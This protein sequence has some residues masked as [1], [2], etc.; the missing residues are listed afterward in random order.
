MQRRGGGREGERV[1]LGRDGHGRRC[2]E[3]HLAPSQGRGGLYTTP[4]TE[5]A[6][7]P[8]LSPAAGGR[9]SVPP[10]PNP[11]GDLSTRGPRRARSAAA[12][13][14]RLMHTAL[15][16]DTAIERARRRPAAARRRRPRGAR[17]SRTS[18]PAA[19]A[20]PGRRSHP[21]DM[22]GPMRAALGVAL[23]IEGV[24]AD[25]GRRARAGRRGRGAAAA[26]P[27]RRRRR[28][29]ERDRHGRRC[30]CSSRA[31]RRPARE[32]WCP[33]NEGSGKVLR[34]GADDAEVVERLRWMRDVL[35]P[36]LA[37]GARAHRAARPD[38]AAAA[39][40]PRAATS[41]TTAP[42]RARGCS[43]DA[44]AERAARRRAR[45]HPRQPPVLPQRRDGRG[46]GRHRG[47]G[48]R[49]GLAARDRGR[50]QRRRGRRA[51]L[52][53]GRRVVHRPG[54]RARPGA[55]GARLRRRRTC[56]A[57]SAT[58]RSSRST[59]SAR[60]RWR[61]RRCRRRPSASTPPTRPR[62]RRACAGSPRPSIPSSGLGR[63]RRRSSASTRAPSCASG[64]VPPIHT[65]IAHREPGV[66]Q[67]GGGVTLPPLEAFD[68]GRGARSTAAPRRVTS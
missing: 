1:R 50:A 60:W 62:S 58:R 49:A 6:G 41:A 18:P 22:C 65:G 57:T 53:H 35:G 39:R 4:S 16:A 37:R 5:V 21:P 15:Y 56:S 26:Q 43:H 51:A 13:G 14:C 44:L 20:T 61:R 27:R 48:G 66:G 46:E 28:A 47:R 54:R 3:V 31:T 23:A 9:H 30:R 12:V 64:I 11:R 7:G 52:G 2:I 40:A 29:D 25:A 24:A 63:R 55:P 33:L 59:G 45:V 36:A 67:I 68:A 38:R 19:R 10:V 17:S 8:T 32:A 42:T 34:Y